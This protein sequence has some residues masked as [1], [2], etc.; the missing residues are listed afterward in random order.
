MPGRRHRWCVQVLRDDGYAFIPNEG[1]PSCDQL[2]QHGPKRVEIR[3]GGY[4]AAQGLFRRHIGGCAHHHAFLCQ[5]GAVCGY[6]KTEVADLGGAVF[7]KPDV[8]GLQIPMDDALA[9]GELLSLPAFACPNYTP[10]PAGQLA[11]HGGAFGSGH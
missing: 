4:V 9:G 1:R 10:M 2:V 3:L 11:P 8:A 6:C 7:R 5:P